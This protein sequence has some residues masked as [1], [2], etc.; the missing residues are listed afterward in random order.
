MLPC[1][2]LSR[3]N[4]VAP[5]T[6]APSY[7]RSRSERSR[8][9]CELMKLGA[10]LG[11]PRS[12]ATRRR[13]LLAAIV[14]VEAFAPRTVPVSGGAALRRVPSRCRGA[15]CDAAGAPLSDHRS[16]HGDAGDGHG[17]VVSVGR[18]ALLG[19]PGW[20]GCVWPAEAGTTGIRRRRAGVCRISW[21]QV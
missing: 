15:A 12:V 5:F 10:P 4:P 13:W 2:V 8:R 17:S 16:A 3:L 19:G 21:Q 7:E 9:C 11:L 6:L 14:Q 18:C 20:V 1:L